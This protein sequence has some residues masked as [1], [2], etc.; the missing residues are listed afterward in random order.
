MTTQPAANLIP[1]QRPFQVT[2]LGWLFIFVGILSATFH[3]WRNPVDRW[4]VPI[5]LVGVV[6]IVAG[7]F[8]LRGARWSRWLL[9][10][11]LAVHV[12]ISALNSVSEALPHIVL[13]AVVTYF[14]LGPPTAAYFH[15]TQ[16]H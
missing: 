3:L 9:I 4:T 6:A 1:T 7:V 15:R 16:P 12:V 2:I 10:A 11:W 8:L 5:M 14:L 13:L